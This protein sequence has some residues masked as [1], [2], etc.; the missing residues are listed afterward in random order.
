MIFTG[1]K[2]KSNQIFFNKNWEELLEKSSL[3]SARLIENALIIVS[4]FTEKEASITYLSNCLGIAENQIDCVVFQK[5]ISKEQ[6]NLGIFTPKDFG[7]N[8][9]LPES[10]LGTIL[11]KNYD[12][13]INYSKVD[14]VYT[15]LLILHCKAAFRVGF[16]HLN[17]NLY[18]F[19]VKCDPTESKLFYTELIKYLKILKKI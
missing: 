3:V 18:N 14:N 13:L 9:K 8:G 11:T 7:W 15:N 4:D 12:L 16:G 5:K 1:F 19:I 6:R 2:R 17:K 10:K